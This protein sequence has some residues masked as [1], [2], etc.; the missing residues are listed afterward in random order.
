MKNVKRNI[1]YCEACEQGKSTKPATRNHGQKGVR[2]T[3][4]LQRIHAGLIGPII[5]ESRGYKYLLTIADGYSRYNMAIPLKKNGEG[6]KLLEAISTLERVTGESVQEV[7]ADWGKEF[8]SN[9]FQGELRQRGIIARETVPCH[10]ET[11]ALIE[12]VNRSIIAIART[13]TIEAKMPGAML[14]NGLPIRKTECHIK[15]QGKL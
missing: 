14:H 1:I 4:I 12:R 3:K 13:A 6:S 15:L 7:Q 5:P 10:S 9:E 8:Q 2:T 11:N